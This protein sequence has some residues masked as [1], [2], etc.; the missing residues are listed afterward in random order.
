MCVGGG[1]EGTDIKARDFDLTFTVIH[2]VQRTHENKSLFH[3][4]CT[5]ICALD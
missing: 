1:E 3:S 2:V 5:N 4:S